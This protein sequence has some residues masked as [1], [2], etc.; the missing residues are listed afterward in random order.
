MFTNTNSILPLFRLRNTSEVS[1]IG[2]DKSGLDSIDDID[3]MSLN[4]KNN[5]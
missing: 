5:V 4:Q 2:I 3:E 1:F